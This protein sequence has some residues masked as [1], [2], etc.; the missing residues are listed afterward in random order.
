MINPADDDYD[1]TASGEVSQIF[2][3]DKELLKFG[4]VVDFIFQWR[5]I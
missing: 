4:F 5:Q 1:D 2:V 3:T